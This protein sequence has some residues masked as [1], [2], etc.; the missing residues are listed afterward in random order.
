MNRT[1]KSNLLSRDSLTLQKMVNSD[2]YIKR[3]YNQ[4]YLEMKKSGAIKNRDSGLELGSGGLN[5]STQHFPKIIQTEGH[6][7]SKQK[8]CCICGKTA[9]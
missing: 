2:H 5:M 6:Y 1:D 7:V 3:V 4:V 9:F 8:Y